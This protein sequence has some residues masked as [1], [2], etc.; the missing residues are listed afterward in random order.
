MKMV[1]VLGLMAVAILGCLFNLLPPVV[2]I[3]LVAAA[4]I[5]WGRDM[6]KPF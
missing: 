1:I 4:M 3:I 6:L 5:L 2:Y